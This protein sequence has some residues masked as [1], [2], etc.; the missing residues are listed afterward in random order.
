MMGYILGVSQNIVAAFLGITVHQ[1]V[2]VERRLAR[3][4][5][6]PPVPPDEAETSGTQ[7]R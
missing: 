3:R 6:A 4:R 5:P 1:L 2:V 7:T